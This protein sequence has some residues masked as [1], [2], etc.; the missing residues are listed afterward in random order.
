[1]ISALTGLVA[2]LVHVLSGPDHLA[3]L[4]PLTV[5]R[6]ARAIRVGI[7]WAIGHSFGV[8]LIGIASFLLRELIP[9]DSTSAYSERIVGVLLIGIGLW[10]LKKAFATRIH[11]HAHAH[12]GEHH[13]H[14]HVHRSGHQHAEEPV[15]F[16][17]HAALGI[18]TLHGL[19]GG[20][21]LIGVL[22]AL[23]LPSRWSA[24]AY[25]ICFGIGTLGGIGLFSS[26]LG[27]FA[28]RFGGQGARTY[29]YLMSGCGLA[30]VAIGSA[31]LIM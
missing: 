8:A 11:A 19:A 24:A 20:S 14:I 7:Q 21:H 10:S 27:L 6:P 13:T 28:G 3:A 25:L 9:L 26:V 16:H 31:W 23:W 4:A 30:A 12:D 5:D 1:M 2:G 18:G 15:H 22:P 29:R 17:S